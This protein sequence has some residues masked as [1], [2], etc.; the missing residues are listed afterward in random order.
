MDIR[1]REESGR[2]GTAKHDSL[3]SVVMGKIGEDL[4]QFIQNARVE[5]V[6]ASVFD[7]NPDGDASVTIIFGAKMMKSVS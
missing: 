7:V 6:H 5:D 4:I 1:T 3:R 2:F